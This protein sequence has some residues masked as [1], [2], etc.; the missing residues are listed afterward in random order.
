MKNNTDILGFIG[1]FFLTINMIPQIYKNFKEK[2]V[3][4]ISFIFLLLNFIG[5]FFNMTYSFLNKIY[6]IA[7]PISLSFFCTCIMIILKIK[8][9][10]NTILPT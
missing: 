1:G 9:K 6:A 10:N 5:L 7:F 4:D 8:Y 2:K 3:D